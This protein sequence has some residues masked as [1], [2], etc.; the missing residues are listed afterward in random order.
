MKHLGKSPN[1]SAF[2]SNH[3]DEPYYTYVKN[4]IKTIEGRLRKG[5]YAE[6]ASGDSIKV[7]TNDKTD[8]FIVKVV[9]I[10]SYPTFK[11]L[12]AH[13]PLQKVLPNVATKDKAFDIYEQFYPLDQQREFGVIA[14]EVQRD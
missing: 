1:G 12:L 14:I 4:G 11:E 3:R 6:L 2:Y 5:L 8:S 13:E 10:R 7:Q 9:D